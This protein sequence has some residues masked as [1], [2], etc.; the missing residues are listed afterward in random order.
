MVHN[1]RIFP[2]TAQKILPEVEQPSSDQKTPDVPL[3]PLLKAAGQIP[4]S[5]QPYLPVP[6]KCQNTC[7]A[8]LFLSAMGQ[9]REIKAVKKMNVSCINTVCTE[10]ASQTTATEWGTITIGGISVQCMCLWAQKEEIKPLQCVGERARS[11]LQFIIGEE[12]GRRAPAC[13]PCTKKRGLL[14]K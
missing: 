5:Q 12:G 4:S 7:E 11:G 1:C 6:Q 2:A 13:G 14:K 8:L 9:E 3:Q 10:T